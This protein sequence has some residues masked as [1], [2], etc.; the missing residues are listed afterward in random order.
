MVDVSRLGM[1]LDFQGI[2]FWCIRELEILDDIR[3]HALLAY[4][5][6]DKK[7]RFLFISLKIDGQDSGS[8]SI[9]QTIWI[10]DLSVQMLPVKRIANLP[11]YNYW[12]FAVAFAPRLDVDVWFIQGYKQS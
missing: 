11:L 2:K 6:P 8:T 7:S 1:I 10:A 4:E 5:N 3:F 9:I 12:F